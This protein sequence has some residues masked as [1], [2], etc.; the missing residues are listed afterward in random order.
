MLLSDFPGPTLCTQHVASLHLS[1][2]YLYVQGNI[3]A[4]KDKQPEVKGRHD[5]TRH[6]WKSAHKGNPQFHCLSFPGGGPCHRAQE[7]GS[8]N[9]REQ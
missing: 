7:V 9:S 1:I 4:E 6:P 3:S 2:C 8:L 5:S